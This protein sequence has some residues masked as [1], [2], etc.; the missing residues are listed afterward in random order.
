MT[1]A[2][3]VGNVLEFETAVRDAIASGRGIGPRLLLAGLVDGPGEQGNGTVRAD[4]PDEARAVVGMYRRHGFVQIK[5][6]NLIQP[7]ELRAITAEAH[8]LGMTVTGHVPFAMDAIG[9]VEAGM[10]GLE[11]SAFMRAMLPPEALAIEAKTGRLDPA[12]ARFVAPDSPE[13]ERVMRLFKERGAV[14]D[15]TLELFELFSH[16]RSIPLPTIEPGIEKLPPTLGWLRAAYRGTAPPESVNARL[17]FEKTLAVVGM[18]HRAGVPIVAGTDVGVY[19]HSLHHELELFVRAGFTP[20]E[21]IQAATVVPARAM[22]L[23]KEVGT[24]ERGK[25]ADVILVDGDPLRSISDIRR[26]SAVMTN[27]RFYESAALWQ[28]SGSSP[29]RDLNGKYAR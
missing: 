29:E 6:Y 10:D 13:V 17:A 18:L 24:L 12:I 2:R 19:A 27:G 26:V 3:D 9:A 20:M 16:D 22:K 7:D 15:P 11:H 4:T 8:R 1:T 28:T 23:D 21:A 5:V 25:R 14:L